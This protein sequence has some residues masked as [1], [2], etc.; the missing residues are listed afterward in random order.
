M[1]LIGVALLGLLVGS[2]LNVVIHR[3]PAD[4]SIAHPESHCPACGHAIR[5][6]HNVPVLGWL[7]LRGRCA[8]CRAPI[9]VRYPAVELLTALLFVV[10]TARLAQLDMLSVLPAFLWFVAAGIAL[11]VID[12]EVGRL[13]D[14]I[15]LSA[16][17]VLAVMLTGA[18]LLT[19]DPQALLRTLV[20]AVAAFA[21]FYLLALAYPGGVGFGDVKLAGLIGGL[22]AYLTYSTLVVGMFAAFVMGAAIGLAAVARGRATRRS[23]VPFGP[24][25]VAGSLVAILAGAPVADAYTRLVMPA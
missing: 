14:V 18:A 24:F 2:F 1:L 13:P 22:L 4:Q 19:G 7:L 16:Y 17:P 9:S 11:A 12:I 21:G 5:R 10:V 23:S 8:D 15:V 20:G 3:V 6:R 25:L